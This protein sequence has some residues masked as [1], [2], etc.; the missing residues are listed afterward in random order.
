LRQDLLGQRPN[1][2]LHNR[3]LQQVLDRRNSSSIEM[4]HRNISA[5]LVELGAMPLTGYKPLPNHQRILVEIVSEK[6]ASDWALDEAALSFVETP[7][8][9]PLI[10]PAMALVVD[11]PA[12]PARRIGEARH[13]WQGLNLTTR[14]YLAREARNR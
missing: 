8:E 1:K 4:K 10:D 2:S 13:A 14:D 9:I 11:R 3:Q 5:V 6:L 12:A 7:A